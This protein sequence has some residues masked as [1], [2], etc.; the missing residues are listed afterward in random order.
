[1]RGRQRCGRLRRLGLW[2]REGPLDRTA[3]THGSRAR[4]R[5][6]K[7]R[8]STGSKSSGNAGRARFLGAIRKVTLVV[9]KKEEH[10]FGSSFLHSNLDSAY[11]LLKKNGFMNR[12][13]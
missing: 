13:W 8:R 12:S 10:D 3:H 4:G 1:M 9:T 2:C 7:R 5:E 6:G 11:F